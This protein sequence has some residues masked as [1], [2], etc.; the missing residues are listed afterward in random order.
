MVYGGGRRTREKTT[1]MINETELVKDVEQQENKKEACW[2]EQD[3]VNRQRRKA[4]ANT[5]TT[6]PTPSQRATGGQR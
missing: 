6:T 5:V 2:D 1:A 4:T 3:K